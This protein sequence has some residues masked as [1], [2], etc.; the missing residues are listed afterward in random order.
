MTSAG[1][2]A[3]SR[4]RTSAAVGRSLHPASKAGDGDVDAEHMRQQGLGAV[5]AEPWP[6]AVRRCAPTALASSL[7][8][9]LAQGVSRVKLSVP[10][11]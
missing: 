2:P 3:L 5:G 8:G 11:A 6:S 10:W 1:R 9:D 4:L 7:G